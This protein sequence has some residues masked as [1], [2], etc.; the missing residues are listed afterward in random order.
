MVQGGCSRQ[1][2]VV[3]WSR[4]V[5]P[6]ACGEVIEVWRTEGGCTS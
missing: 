1:G 4:K 3:V 2:I 6:S 5:F